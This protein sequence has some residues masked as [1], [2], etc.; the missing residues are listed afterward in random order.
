MT[1]ENLSC[2][3]NFFPRA[4]SSVGLGMN[5]T[6]AKCRSFYLGGYTGRTQRCLCKIRTLFLAYVMF[7]LTDTVSW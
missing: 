1:E 2:E 3:G 4:L 5:L 6:L 7:I